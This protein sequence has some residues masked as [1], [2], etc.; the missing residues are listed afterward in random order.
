MD[1]KYEPFLDESN[2]YFI[3]FEEF[4]EDTGLRSAHINDNDEHYIVHGDRDY[5]EWEES[6]LEDLGLLFESLYTELNKNLIYFYG[7]Q[8]NV[9]LNTYPSRL[10]FF[11]DKYLDATEADFCE[12]ELEKKIIHYVSSDLLKGKITYSLKKRSSFLRK[13][14]VEL[15]TKQQ[16]QKTPQL[17][18]LDNS[19]T[20]IIDVPKGKDYKDYIWFKT[21]IPLATG[22]AF[23]LYNKYKLDKGHFM[24]ICIDLG[25]KKSDRPYFSETINDNSSTN[26]DKNTFANKDKLQKLHKHLTENNLNFGARF[27]KKYNEIE[28]E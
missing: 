27:L 1:Y 13:R 5:E 9:Y 23:D 10:Q 22:E 7:C 18:E 16:N 21:G 12:Y 6:E 2:S 28:L 26:S 17:L 11:L 19:S 8:F 20:S 3:A 15:S 25:F 14:I 4:K 24:R